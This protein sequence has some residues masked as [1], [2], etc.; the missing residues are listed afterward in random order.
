MPPIKHI[1]LAPLTY[2]IFTLFYFLLLV[3]NN[4]CVYLQMLV[5]LIVFG[6]CRNS[7]S[8]FSKDSDVTVDVTHLY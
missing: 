3:K 2:Q 5:V 4:I 8:H 6:I 7:L 1:L